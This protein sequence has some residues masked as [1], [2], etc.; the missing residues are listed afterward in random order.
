[1]LELTQGT[2]GSII[3]TLNELK[4]IDAPYY[5]FVFEHTSTRDT[6]KL[7]KNSTEDESEYPERYNEFAIDASV[8]TDYQDGEW[9]YTI[10]EQSSSTNLDPAL[11]SEVENGKLKLNPA[12]EFEYTTYNQAQ[13]YKQYNG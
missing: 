6:V 13:T 4:T 1:M 8:F 7:I 3:V 11:A 12:T 10:Y 5:L 9:H 2:S